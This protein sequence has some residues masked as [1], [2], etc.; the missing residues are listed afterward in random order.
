VT[1]VVKAIKRR[2]RRISTAA[3]PE[4]F[5]MTMSD[6]SEEQVAA[7]VQRMQ[8]A[9]R[10]AGVLTPTKPTPSTPTQPTPRQVVFAQIHEERRRQDGQWGGPDHDNEHSRRVW[11]GLIGEHVSRAVKLARSRSASAGDS[12]RH[13]LIATAALCVAAI[14]AYD[15]K[16]KLK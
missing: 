12:Y 14:E 16:D 2:K 4:V 11:A 10:A 1:E 6:L 8:A 5:A 9:A 7:I 3:Q 15:R 13:R